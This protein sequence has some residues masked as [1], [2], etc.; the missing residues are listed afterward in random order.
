MTPGGRVTAMNRRCIVEPSCWPSAPR[1]GIASPRCWRPIR[2]ASPAVRV[3]VTGAGSKAPLNSL[4]I[5]STPRRRELEP[6]GRHGRRFAAAP[7]P[8]FEGSRVA[9]YHTCCTQRSSAC[10]A[11]RINTT[12]LGHTSETWLSFTWCGSK[13]PRRQAPF[14]AC[15]GPWKARKA[16]P[17]ASRL[18]PSHRPGG[19]DEHNQATRGPTL[20]HS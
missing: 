14:E 6:G 12:Y 20:C 19:D 7:A 18:P 1:S 10:R 3:A 16:H 5:D 17:P 15:N 13:P 8:A 2:C 9:C 11:R 4:T